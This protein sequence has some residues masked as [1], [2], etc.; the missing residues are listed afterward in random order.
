MATVAA[1]AAHQRLGW[2]YAFYLPSI[3]VVVVGWVSWVSLQSVQNGP[4]K[5]KSSAEKAG[6]LSVIKLP[7]VVPLGLSY[8]CIK[9]VRYIGILWVPFFLTNMGVEPEIAAF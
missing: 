2:R 6:V 9:L 1:A 4:S 5:A 7:S 3:W 8:F